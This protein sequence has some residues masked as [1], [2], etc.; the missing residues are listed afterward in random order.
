[1]ATK[2]REKQKI[3]PPFFFLELIFFC[4]TSLH[5]PIFPCDILFF[6]PSMTFLSLTLA[7]PLPYPCLIPASSLPHSCLGPSNVCPRFG[8]KAYF[9]S[10]VSLCLAFFFLKPLL[11]SLSPLV[12]RFNPSLT[13]VRATGLLTLY[14]SLLLSL[15]RSISY[16]H[17]INKL[18]DDNN[19][20]MK[21][22]FLVL[23]YKHFLFQHH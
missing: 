11:A 8:G 7:S 3:F 22:F 12:I 10:F 5:P 16:L 23:W 14:L 4:F 13:P 18:Y 1:M 6:T 9:V 21:V 20:F 17:E 15:F 19:S 2:H